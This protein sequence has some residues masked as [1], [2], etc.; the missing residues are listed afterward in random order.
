MLPWAA[1]VE[2]TDQVLVS[3]ATGTS[4][5]ERFRVPVVA[6]SEAE[7]VS[8]AAVGLIAATLMVTVAVEAW[9]EPSVIVYVNESTPLKPALGVY[10]NLPDVAK[11]AAGVMLPCA[12]VVEATDQVLTS[13]ATGES[14]NARFS[15]PVVP[16]SLAWNV[17][18]AAVGLIA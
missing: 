2:A 16:F 17:S 11:S 3:P 1:V 4:L 12:V 15:V 10:V 9:P 18:L 5:A 7:N 6:F 8:L 13:P 14:L